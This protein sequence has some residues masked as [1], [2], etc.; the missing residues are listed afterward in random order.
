M[1]EY[2]RKP[3][4]EEMEEVKAPAIFLLPQTL[5]LESE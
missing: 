3:L 5:R 1:L 4:L 2:L